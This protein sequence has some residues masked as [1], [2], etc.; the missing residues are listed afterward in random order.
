MLKH[1]TTQRQILA[2]KPGRY[3]YG[4]G[5]CLVVPRTKRQPK[6]KWIY[7]YTSPITKR[8]TETSIGS[9]FGR[10]YHDARNEAYRLHSL[11]ENGQDPVQAKKQE[12]VTYGEAC[13]AFIKHNAPYRW[14]STKNAKNLLG[15]PKGL[16]QIPVGMITPSMI[17]EA[18][19]PVWEKHPHQVI[20]ALPMI[21]AVF[22]YAKFMNWCAGENPAAW[23]GNMENVFVGLQRRD[24]HYASLQ[25]EDLPEF[26]QRLKLRQVRGTSAAALEFLILTAARTGEVLGAR[27]SE[28][29]LENKVWVIPPERMKQKRQ[30]RVP[31]S[32]RCMA[33]LA[34]Q[35]EYRQGEFVF[36]GYNKTRM[37]EATLRVLLK[38]MDVSVTPHGFR[39]SFRN[40]AFTTRQARDLAELSLSHLVAENRTEGAYLTVNG[41]EERRPLMEAWSLYCAGLG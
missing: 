41:L 33:I 28:L 23:K 39:S 15:Q 14:R 24:N 30:H 36:T 21:A 16:D 4:H 5:L 9:A 12:K 20:R 19:M 34:L 2:A 25:F 11:V 37:D 18:L 35:R 22:R 8:V 6:P 31:L 38:S 27:W 3:Y 7:R 13:D 17:K 40:W 26:M 10:T 29:D 32:E 1:P